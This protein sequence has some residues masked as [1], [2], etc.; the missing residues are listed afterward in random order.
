[1]EQR[2]G[3]ERI[4]ERTKKMSRERDGGE[5]KRE[6]RISRAKRERKENKEKQW[7]ILKCTRR[8]YNTV[9]VGGTQGALN[10]RGLGAQITCLVLGANNPHYENNFTVRGL[11][12]LGNF[13]KGSRH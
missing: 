11:H 8:G 5:T 9:R 6:I 7:H 2:K 4:R 1:M 3:R 12:N 13:I 10:V